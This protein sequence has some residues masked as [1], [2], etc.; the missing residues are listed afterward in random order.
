M[1]QSIWG[2]TM[3]LMALL[4]C[5]SDEED[6]QKIDQILSFYMKNAAGKDLFNPTA[7]GS[8]SQIKMNDVFGEADN[9]PV[10]FSGP[11]IQIDSTYKIEYTAGAK[12]RL[13]SSDANDNRL[14]QSK[15]ALNMRQKINDTLFQTILDTMEIQYRWSPTL[16]EVSK[17][18]YNKN[19]VFNKTPTSGNTFTITK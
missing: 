12:R 14:Y 4:S 1:K 9:S 6:I 7:V 3:S 17:V 19:E 13:L 10:T 5:K 2:I 11:T 16:F 15:I 18:L 8:Y